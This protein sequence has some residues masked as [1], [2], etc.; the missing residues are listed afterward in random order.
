MNHYFDFTDRQLKFVGVLAILALI[1]CGYLLVRKISTPARESAS[2]EVFIGE[3]EK[4]FSGSFVLDP[5]TAPADSLELLPGIGPV[6][7]DRIVARRE[8]KLFENEIDLVDVRGIGPR[9]YERLRPYVRIA[10]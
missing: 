4:V 6:L 10:K 3:N 8:V 1:S 5:N 7:A 9:L 2:F